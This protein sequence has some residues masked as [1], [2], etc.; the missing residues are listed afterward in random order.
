MSPRIDG[1][2]LIKPGHQRQITC[3]AGN[4]PGRSFRQKSRNQKSRPGNLGQA[5]GNA[6]TI[7]TENRSAANAAGFRDCCSE[8]RCPTDALLFGSTFRTPMSRSHHNETT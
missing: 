2:I 3:A 1:F 8:S 7:Q 4:S 5:F 6:A